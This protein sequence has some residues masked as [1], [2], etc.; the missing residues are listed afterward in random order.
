MGDTGTS[1]SFVKDKQYDLCIGDFSRSVTFR[2]VIE[3]YGNRMLLF[4]N[5]NPEGS[6]RFLAA[7]PDVWIPRSPSPKD[8]KAKIHM[9]LHVSL[10]GNTLEELGEPG[11]K[12][13]WKIVY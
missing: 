11:Y 12:D 6:Y 10:F 9:N 13:D 3:K 7:R 2:G 5:E 1:L 8:G 4:E